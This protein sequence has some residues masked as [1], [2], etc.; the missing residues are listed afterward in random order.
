[1]G[2]ELKEDKKFLFGHK[3]R[4][5]RTIK[6]ELLKS[7]G[8]EQTSGLCGNNILGKEQPQNNFGGP[9]NLNNQRVQLENGRDFV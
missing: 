6:W 7:S 9:W 4:G 8:G 1:V 2:S 5:I 3:E